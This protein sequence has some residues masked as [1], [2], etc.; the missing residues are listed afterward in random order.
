[1][2]ETGAESLLLLYK[3][4]EQIPTTDYQYLD[5]DDC[6]NPWGMITL[7]QIYMTFN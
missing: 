5:N 4:Q 2:A 6:S 1:M 7:R 3:P